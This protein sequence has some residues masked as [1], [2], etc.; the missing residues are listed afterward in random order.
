MIPILY[1]SHYRSTI[2][3]GEKQLYYLVTH[4]D[5]N[6]FQPIVVCPNDGSY[7]HQLRQAG[8]STVILNL[9]PWRKLL[10]YP[11]RHIAAFKLTNLA[12]KYK[13]KIGHSSDPWLNPYV[14]RIKKHLNVPVISHVPNLLT[15]KQVAKYDF[16]YMNRII[17]ISEQSKAPI[18]KAGISSEKIDVITNCVDLSLFQ[19]DPIKSKTDSNLFIVGIVGRIEPFKRQ[20]TFI[21]IANK[22]FQRCE[23]VRFHIIG[24]SLNTP[25]HR[26]YQHETHQLVS[27]YKLENV[28]HFTGHRNDIHVAMREL[29]ILVTLSAGSVIAEAMATGK[30][31]IG[32][33][34]GSTSEMIVDNVTGWVIPSDSIEGIADRIIQLN[35]DR[36][37]CDQMGVA[38]RK[39]A[40]AT[41]SIKEHVHKIQDIYTAEA[42]NCRN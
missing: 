42:F 41:F 4:L 26:A 21:E 10:S 1:L 32:T 22:V 16:E 2:G 40:E 37:L 6:K 29:D 35:T 20:K 33:P 30:P 24:A 13:I 19:P 18:V 5:K 27:K 31:V 23:N 3:G 17:A 12:K 36:E 8:I 11:T 7:V 9:P 15:P 28:V 39:H 38:A 34:I 25:K 14:K